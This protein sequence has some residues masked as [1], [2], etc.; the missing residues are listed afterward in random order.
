VE[1]SGSARRLRVLVCD[2]PGVRLDEVTRTVARLDHDVIARE[3][4]LPDVARITAAERPDVALVIVH[5]ESPKALELIDQIVREA[6]CPVIA[7]LDVQDRTFVN[8]AAKR[9]IFAYIAHGGDPQEMQSSIDIVL[10][11]FAEYHNLEGAF[12]RRAVTERAKGILME[13]H[14]IDEEEAFKML[15]EHARRTRRKVQDLAQAVVDGHSLLPG[16]PGRIAP[17][18]DTDP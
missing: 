1:E 7:V 8:E 17:T 3:S 10:R 16:H 12:G 14:G 18:D 4:S 15:R 2:E 13:R 11:R 6:T 9:G 5:E